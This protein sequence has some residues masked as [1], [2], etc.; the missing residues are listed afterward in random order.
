MRVIPVI[1]LLNGQVVRGVAGR[2]S[3][4]RP[5]LS[6]IASDA[7]PQTVA[8]A[9]VNHFAFDTAYVADLDAIL[10]RHPS[11]EAWQQ[12]AAAGLK[13]WLDAGVSD[14]ATARGVL[15][16]ASAAGIDVQLVIGLESLAS[17][18]ELAAIRSLCPTS[19]IFSLDLQAGQPLTQIDDCQSLSPFAIAERA[20]NA[21]IDQMILLDL[22]DVGVAGG[23]RTVELCH[24]LRGQHPHLRLIGGG[25]VRGPGDLQTLADAGFDAALVASALHDGRL[26]RQDAATGLSTTAL[27][28]S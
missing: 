5:I 9:F 3:E 22:A 10:H 25:G 15:Q 7:Q 12:I 4:Y 14:G 16:H 19:P 11:I 1:D 28:S 13:L 21:G 18:A 27:T 6:Q 26:S 2:R 24:L 20:I 17:F 23:T 8:Q